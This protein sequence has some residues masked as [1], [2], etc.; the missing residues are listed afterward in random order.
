MPVR[1]EGTTYNRARYEGVTYNRMRFGGVT[2]ALG[3]SE[4][5][6]GIRTVVILSIGASINAGSAAKASGA[7]GSGPES[8]GYDTMTPGADAKQWNDSGFVDVDDPIGT[9]NRTGQGSFWPSL[10]SRLSL[11]YESPNGDPIR[12]RLLA[13]SKGS[14]MLHVS[15]YVSG[16]TTLG[17]GDVANPDSLWAY[18][19]AE[20]PGFWSAVQAEEGFDADNCDIIAVTNFGNEAEWIRE[21][22]NPSDPREITATDLRARF[23]GIPDQIEEAIGIAPDAVYLMPSGGPPSD[24]DNAIV[25][26]QRTAE[27]GGVADAETAGDHMVVDTDEL[28]TIVLEDAAID[29]SKH[30]IEDS[31]HPSKAGNLRLGPARA[32]GIATDLGLTPAS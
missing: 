23:A 30:L 28:R 13:A 4:P 18:P 8:N 14:S 24:P 20:W 29:P 10:V 3:E 31:V 6:P 27:T 26:P 7:D 21:T 19:V 9:G 15:K 5:E 32:D 12:V 17:Y 1:F 25:A 11:A 16:V 22:P 2:Y